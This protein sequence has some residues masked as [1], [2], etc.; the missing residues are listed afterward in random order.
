[1]TGEHGKRYSRLD[2][3]NLKRIEEF[4]N[5]LKE[6]L[7]KELNE[8]RELRKQ[9]EKDRAEGERTIESGS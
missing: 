7:R 4:V 1:M 6:D 8:K 2:D 5:E 9:S 3:A